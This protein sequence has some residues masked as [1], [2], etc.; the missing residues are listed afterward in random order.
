MSEPAPPAAPAKPDKASFPL[1][2]KI[3]L[4]STCLATLPLAGVGV[5]LITVNREAVVNLSREIQLSVLDDLARTIDQELVG[6][7]DALDMAGGLFAD[8][9]IDDE[10]RITLL[11]AQVQGQ[12]AIDHVALYDAEGERIA[13]IE[14]EDTSFELPQTLPQALR[15]QIERVHHAT[16]EVEIHDGVPRVLVAVRIRVGDRT[17]GYVAS[18]VSLEDVQAR[19][20]RLAEGHFPGQSNALFVVDHQLRTIAH[21]DRERAATLAS[22]ADEGILEGVTREMLGP[23]FSQAGEFAAADGTAMLGSSVGM[24]GQPWALVAQTPQEVAYASLTRMTYLIVG[25]VAG[26]MLL[27]LILG[28]LV[29]RR[30][31]SPLAELTRF[32]HALASRQWSQR[33]AVA[34]SDELAVLGRAMNAAAGDLEASEEKL[35]QEV[36]IRTDLGRYV[37]EQLVE[38]IVKRER[39]MA[40]GGTRRPI[41]VLFADVVGFTPM[42]DQLPPETVVTIL[43]ELFTILTQIVFRHDGTVDKFI[44]DCVMAIWGAP[45]SQEDHVTR[46]LDAAEE[47]LSWL[48]TGN[49]RWQALHGVTIQLAIGIHTGEAVVGNIGSEKR[50]EYTAIGDVVNVAAR[51][52]AIARPQQILVTDKVVEAA[53]DAYDFND[54]DLHRLSG[55][56]EPVH[57][58]EVIT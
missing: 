49:E 11:T 5:A 57:L 10:Q 50:M 7:Q 23:G 52:E 42:T 17:T 1:G 56:A 12:E 33:A 31:S 54:A 40:L 4:L 3:A 16:G 35:K 14:S 34:T 20:E 8:G 9:T 41:T 39:D 37:P 45:T 46:A 13:V 58:Y 32:A 43:N 2:L 21:N 36:A 30:I 26:A 22:A 19:V 48:E 15:D 24:E 25:T 6:A 28:L 55:R 27:A 29:A 53:G 47:M 38:Q 51:L 44:G 18:L